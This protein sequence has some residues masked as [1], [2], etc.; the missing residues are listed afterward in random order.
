MDDAEYQEAQRLQEE[1]KAMEV[2]ARTFI[3]G[4]LGALD[5]PNEQGQLLMLLN[6]GTI[7]CNL[8]NKVKPGSCK[9][10]STSANPY[11]QKKNIENYINAAAAL[12]VPEHNS[13]EV[14]DLYEGK[15]L[16]DRIMA[17]DQLLREAPNTAD[18][19]WS[20]ILTS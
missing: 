11:H 16:L 15:D 17:S 19:Q 6:D 18:N 20:P 8:I 2:E 3:E 12:G 1:G 13:F 14:M 9:E 4:N 10:P 7:L 5:A